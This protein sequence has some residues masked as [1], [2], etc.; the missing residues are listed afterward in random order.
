MGE[1]TV[2]FVGIC[3][4][5][6]DIEKSIPG[7]RRRVVLV[8]AREPEI[9]NQTMIPPHIPTLRIAASDLEVNGVSATTENGCV[10]QW[11]LNGCKIEIVD[12][13]GELKHDASFE[14]CVPH[15]KIL[16]PDADGVSTD[17]V[18][19]GK[20]EVTS[21]YF[22]LT[23]GHLSAG[24]IANGAA[25]SVLRTQTATDSP[26]LRIQQFRT[27]NV[28][29]FRLRSGAQIALMNVGDEGLAGDDTTDF[30][31][32]YK[33]V[34]NVPENAAIPTSAAPCCR[35]LGSSYILPTGQIGLGPGCSNSSFP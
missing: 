8:N 3:T 29:E 1:I 11:E 33:V 12:A 26:V 17:V 5:M 6:E 16:T 34:E 9:I 22:D 14:C 2:Y 15:L 32:H 13:E 21:C 20:S 24:L 19:A 27:Q 23:A 10:L 18:L 35:P 28:Q 25:V 31:L 7:V 4:F 30:L